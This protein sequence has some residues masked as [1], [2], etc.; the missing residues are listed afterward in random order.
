MVKK[1]SNLDRDILEFRD[2]LDEI[3][4]KEV[5]KTVLEARKAIKKGAIGIPV[6]KLFKKNRKQNGASKRHK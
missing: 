5:I 3:S 4:N 6:S 2:I 1:L